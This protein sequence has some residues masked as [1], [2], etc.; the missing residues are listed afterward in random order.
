MNL[1]TQLV[2]EGFINTLTPEVRLAAR[3]G[4]PTMSTQ[5]LPCLLGC[6]GG[7]AMITTRGAC[8][9]KLQVISSAK[10]CRLYHPRTRLEV[11]SAYT[12]CWWASASLQR[13][14]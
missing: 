5:A 12:V 6:R 10:P 4:D 9:R 8:G 1:R 13:P 2:D 7:R 11:A 3:Q 14:A